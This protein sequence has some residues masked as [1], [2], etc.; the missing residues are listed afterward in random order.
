MLE[1][2][3]KNVKDV[4]LDRARDLIQM[5]PEILAKLGEKGRLRRET[6][7]REETEKIRKKYGVR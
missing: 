2:P 7:E 6:E 4:L 5:P 3:T 1:D